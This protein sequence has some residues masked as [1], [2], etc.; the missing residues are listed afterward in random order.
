MNRHK[1]RSGELGG[2]REGLT[3]VD[4]EAEFDRLVD[5]MISGL[6]PVG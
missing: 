6:I 1:P 2:R 4:P 5:R 3:D